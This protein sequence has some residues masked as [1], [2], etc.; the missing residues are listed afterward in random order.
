MHIISASRRTDI[1]QYYAEWFRARR[2]AGFAEYRTV[3]GGGA[4]GY[5]RASL[6]PEKVLGYLFWTK[7]AGPFHAELKALREEKTPYVFQY[8][9][10]GYGKETESGIPERAAV[11]KDFIKVAKSLP[12]PESI[13]WRYDPIL[14]STKVYTHAWHR[15]NFKEIAARLSGHTR[16]VNV[17]FTEPYQKAIDKVPE[18]HEITWRRTDKQRAAIYKKYPGL[19]AAGELEIKLLDDL[20]AIAGEY[21]MQLRVCCN[22]EYTDR[23]PAAQCCGAELFAPY[24][25]VISWQVAALPPGPSRESCRCVKTV[26]IGMDNTCP[27]GCFYCYVM[28]TPDMVAENFKHHDP[29]SPHLR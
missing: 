7:Y 9:I 18:G 29:K 8:T 23:F 6:E 1:P 10:T 27:G 3:Y 19:R 12:G 15:K 24:G 4:A 25:P 28:T 5:F 22:S 11:I 16:V 13:Q 21:D 14:I 20:A 17:S 26:D 2:K